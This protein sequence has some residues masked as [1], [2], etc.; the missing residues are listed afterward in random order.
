MLSSGHLNGDFFIY[1][2]DFF[3]LFFS[4]ITS[5]I[6]Y[7]LLFAYLSRK[8]KESIYVSIAEFKHFD[9]IVIGLL[10][11]NIFLS[12]TYKVGLY[13]QNQ[14]YEVPF[15]I[16]PFIVVVNKL[17]MYIFSGLLLM[18]NRFSRTTKL[19]VIVL[20]IILSISRASI[21][22]FLFLFLVFIANGSVKL[23]L[24]QLLLICLTL[25][26]TFKYL[27]KLF[28]Y[29]EVLRKGDSAKNIEIFDS[30][31]LND[32]IKSKVIG[33]ISSLSS[34]A[35]FYQNNGEINRTQNQVGSL[36]YIVEGFRPFYGGVIRE[37]KIGYTYYFTNFY[38]SKAGVDYG[39]M[40]GL[41]SV[42]LVSYFKGLHVFLIN[43]IF[44]FVLIYSVIILSSFLF[45]SAYREFCFVLL[46]YPMMSGVPSEFGQIILYLLFISF[47]KILYISYLRYRSK[48]F[49]NSE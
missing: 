45:G 1:D 2:S 41:P 30:K 20:L 5:F 25:I 44:I 21:I 17:D 28:E 6:P 27:P 14:I 49:I 47:L 22:V 37:N 15:F 34:I 7:L 36:E 48:N 38:D 43:L 29:R 46:F 39:I 9:K 23:K 32:F 4:F 8:K 26:M 13:A 31:E 11:V 12:L 33:R 40:Y 3:W 10:L 42:F 19:I 16:K 24:K 18:S 35:F